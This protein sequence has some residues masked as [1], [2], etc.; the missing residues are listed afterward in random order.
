MFVHPNFKEWAEGRDLDGAE[1]HVRRCQQA[2]DNLQAQLEAL[3]AETAEQGQLENLERG[4]ADAEKHLAAAK[5]QFERTKM[6]SPQL[7]DGVMVEGDAEQPT[8][9]FNHL[10]CGPLDP[11]SGR[12]RVI[13]HY[14]RLEGGS[15][16][17]HTGGN[18]AYAG[19]PGYRAGT[20]G[21]PAAGNL[22][23]GIHLHLNSEDMRA[24][25]QLATQVLQVVRRQAP[26]TDP[27][28]AGLHSG[29][30][31]PCRPP[32]P[33]R[34]DSVLPGQVLLLSSAH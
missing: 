12:Y 10:S 8:P 14:T 21:L 33:L 2:R 16:R 24:A 17:L 32:R 9:E 19:F 27:P 28:S 26:G 1:G 18:Q 15:I 7:L 29:Q 13:E 30:A 11:V 3:G 20:E 22:Y 34:C 31:G 25:K 23:D 6:G 4:I 5:R